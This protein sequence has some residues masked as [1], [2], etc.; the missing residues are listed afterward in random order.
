MAETKGV[1]LQAYAVADESGSVPTAAMRSWWGCGVP[2]K[3]R[4]ATTVAGVV[5]AVAALAGC[6]GGGLEGKIGDYDDVSVWP[7]ADPRGQKTIDELT[8]LA[9][10]TVEC[11]TRGDVDASGYGYG[12]KYKISYDGGAGYIDESTSIM[13]EKGE[14]SP[15][16]VPEC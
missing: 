7:S 1:L 2:Q 4:V 15:D 13:S 9:P 11:Y 12:G 6:D 10:V 5:L 14:V 16:M 8:T 3:K